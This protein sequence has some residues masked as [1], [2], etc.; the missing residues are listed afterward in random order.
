MQI[1]VYRDRRRHCRFLR[2]ALKIA[3]FINICGI[4]I[5]IIKNKYIFLYSFL[6]LQYF[7][8][9]FLSMSQLKTGFPP[10]QL[11]LPTAREPS[12][13]DSENDEVVKKKEKNKKRKSLNSSLVPELRILQHDR[14]SAFA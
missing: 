13:S 8:Q 6:F 11:S 14:N 5:E 12:V 2:S 4:K 7:L 9:L 1:G 3:A 10:S